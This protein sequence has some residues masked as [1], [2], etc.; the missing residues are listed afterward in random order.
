MKFKIDENLPVEL[1]ELLLAANYDAQTVYDQ[2]LA[3]EDGPNINAICKRED[4]VLITLDLDF[5]DIRAYP[6]QEYPGVMVLRLMRQDKLHLIE[7]FR[8]TIPLLLKS[9]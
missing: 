8:R 1:A 7:V 2:G 6:P 9:L 5:T 4:R 3:G